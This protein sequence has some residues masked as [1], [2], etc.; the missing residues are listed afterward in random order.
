MDYSIQ[1]MDKKK[2][3]PEECRLI[4]QR[5]NRALIQQL[6]SSAEVARS[7]R[8][9]VQAKTRQD[10][11]AGADI[12]LVEK[13]AIV[14]WERAE[15]AARLLTGRSLYRRQGGVHALGRVCRYRGE[16]VSALHGARVSR[17]GIFSGKTCKYRPARRSFL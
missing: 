16:T 9:W 17:R 6:G 4:E 1:L 15:T 2:F 13:Q 5:Y 11:M 8:A 12:S 3:S 14:H 10:E 7:R